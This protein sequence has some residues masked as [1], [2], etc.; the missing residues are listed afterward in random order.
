MAMRRDH[1]PTGGSLGKGE[2]INDYFRRTHLAGN[3]EGVPLRDNFI[4]AR[5]QNQHRFGNQPSPI[6]PFI[7][8]AII[9]F[10]RP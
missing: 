5:L 7:F 2:E 3:S 10:C 9:R 6:F 1:V 8:S 4:T